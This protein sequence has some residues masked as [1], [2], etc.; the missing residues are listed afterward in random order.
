MLA[1]ALLEIEAQ[2]RA[3]VFDLEMARAKT[4]PK[5]RKIH[6]RLDRAASKVADQN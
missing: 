1:L 4:P 2:D 3:K 5:W 6:D